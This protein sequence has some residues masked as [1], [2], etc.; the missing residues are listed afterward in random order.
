MFNNQ[1]V[2]KDVIEGLQSLS[3]NSADIIIADPPYNIGKTFGEYNDNLDL[4]DYLDWCKIWI[5]E[6]L[7]VLKPEGTLY[8]YG[9]S[10]VLSYI[11]VNTNCNFKKWLIWHYTNKN[12]AHSQFWQRSHESIL[13]L[14]NSK[15]LFNRDDV[16]EPYTENFLKN[17][18]G[19]PR[20]ATKGRFNP[21]AQES[22]YHAHE[23][24]ALPRDVISFNTSGGE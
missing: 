13:L 12:V 3:D 2:L 8:I 10:E 19:K 11:F 14:A 21:N 6:S 18:A 4:N 20:T 17:S 15:P 23:K 7:R 16:R 5:D 1:I 9:F 24:G 22:T